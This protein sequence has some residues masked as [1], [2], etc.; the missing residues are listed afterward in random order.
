MP[1]S[2]A[3]FVLAAPYEDVAAACADLTALEALYGESHTTR[4]LDAVVVE[5]DAY[6]QVLLDEQTQPDKGQEI[7]LAIG[8]ASTLFP[9]IGVGA[10]LTVPGGGAAVGAIVRH[11][12]AD[13]PREELDQLAE[14][15]EAAEAGLVVVY[16]ESVAQ[17]VEA[18]VSSDSHTI[19]RASAVDPHQV[20]RDAGPLTDPVITKK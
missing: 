20:I 1:D 15:L 10:A 4:A 12:H 18:T 17:K 9:P 3:L 8:V 2:E 13:I 11:L 6:G 7:G 5:R 19:I 14:M 16:D